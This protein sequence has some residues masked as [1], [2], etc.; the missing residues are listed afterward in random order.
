MFESLLEVDLHFIRQHT[1]LF[2]QLKTVVCAIH[3]TPK[4]PDLVILDLMLQIIITKE[5]VCEKMTLN[6]S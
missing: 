5:C 3:C 2:F 6:R 4:Y 1:H